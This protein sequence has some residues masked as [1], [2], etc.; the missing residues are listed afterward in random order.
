VIVDIA[1]G[2]VKDYFEY[3]SPRRR[4]AFAIRR[5]RPPPEKNGVVTFIVRDETAEV[6]VIVET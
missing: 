1:V 5:W 3:F 4:R 6:L 2:G